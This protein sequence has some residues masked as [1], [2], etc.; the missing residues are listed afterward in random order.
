M[1]AARVTVMASVTQLDLSSVHG[2]TQAVDWIRKNILLSDKPQQRIL[3]LDVKLKLRSSPDFGVVTLFIDTENA[4]LFAFRGRDKVYI[5]R[6]DRQNVYESLLKQSGSG[7]VAVLSKVGSDHRSLGTLL[8]NTDSAGMRGRSYAMA[9]LQDAVR[10]AN[11]SLDHGPITEFDVAESMSI[12]VCMLAECA[13]WPR[14]ERAFQRI[15]FGENVQADEVFNVYG[16]AKRIRELASVF[17][18]RDLDVSYRVERLVKRANELNELLARLRARPGTPL[19]DRELIKLCLQSSN[20]NPGGDKDSAQR[21]RM[22][23]TELKADTD[24]Q[25]V[26]EILSLCA[27][28]QAVRAAQSGVV[29]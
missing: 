29:G 24:P 26:M 14:I 27:N 28:E 3:A 20:G 4:Y 19:D 10:L 12:L 17:R 9:H 16:R 11:Y 25:K 15:Y 2:F 23:C 5:L 21:I 22:I 8:P 18:D 7:P 13:R 6:D 1:D